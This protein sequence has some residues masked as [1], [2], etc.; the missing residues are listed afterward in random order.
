MKSKLVKF[1]LIGVAAYIFIA[2]FREFINGMFKED[3]PVKKTL[4]S[5]FKGNVAPVKNTEQVQ[6]N[7]EIE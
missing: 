4:K 3:S 2:P 6:M 1:L 5:I 7:T